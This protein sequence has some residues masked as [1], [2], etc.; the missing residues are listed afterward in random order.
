MNKKRPERR[1]RYFCIG[2]SNIDALM[3]K[4]PSFMQEFLTNDLSEITSK[5]IFYRDLLCH[6]QCKS[7]SD[8]TE[9]Y[10]LIDDYYKLYY[11]GFTKTLHR[12][13]VSSSFSN[14]SGHFFLGEDGYAKNGDYLFLVYLYH[15]VK[16]L[17]FLGAEDMNIAD[18]MGE[19][20]T[21]FI[22]QESDINAFFDSILHVEETINED[23]E[24]IKLLYSPFDKLAGFEKGSDV[25]KYLA[26]PYKEAIKIKG[27]PRVWMM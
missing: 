26:V 8:E 16:K 1:G 7:W 13:C 22:K 6:R 23:K 3:L 27:F 11:F 10:I 14:F 20:I 9:K 24:T 4:Y 18:L 25:V 17:I 21:T 12:D 15:L 2:I 5:K 19:G